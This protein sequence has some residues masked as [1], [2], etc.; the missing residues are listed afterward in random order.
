MGFVEHPGGIPFVVLDVARGF[1]SLHIE[2]NCIVTVEG[3]GAK[4]AR[5]QQ[6]EEVAFL[7]DMASKDVGGGSSSRGNV[8]NATPALK[9]GNVEG[10]IFGGGIVLLR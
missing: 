4:S 10:E 3:A 9:T 7:R 8:F 5:L 1:T 2:A 6:V